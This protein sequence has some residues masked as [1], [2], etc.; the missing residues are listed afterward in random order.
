MYKRQGLLRSL[1]AL[2]ANLTTLDRKLAGA[3]NPD[4][5]ADEQDLSLI[6]I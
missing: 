3:S 6:H 4:A 2:A 5:I 1:G